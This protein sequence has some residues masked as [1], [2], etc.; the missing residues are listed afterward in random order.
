LKSSLVIVLVCLSGCAWFHGKKPVVPDAPELVVTG[1][2]AGSRLFIDGRQVGDTQEAG[3]RPRVVDVA[4][5][6]HTLEVKVGDAVVYREDTDVAPGEKRVITVLSG[7][8]R[9]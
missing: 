8:S 2:P 4:A 1:A 7:N 3:N 5:G 9:S 6:S